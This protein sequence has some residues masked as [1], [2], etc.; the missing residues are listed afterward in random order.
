SVYTTLDAQA[1][2]W[3]VDAVRKGARMYERR[4]GWKVKFDN[5]IDQGKGG[6]GGVTLATLE[7]YR[8]PS[9]IA[10]P[11]V[12]DIMTGMIKEV[13]ERNAQVTFGSYSAVITAEQTEALSKPPSKIFKRGDLAQFKIEAVDRV[14]KTMSVMLD[15]EPDVQ[16]AL[17]LLDAKTGE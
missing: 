11:E 8:H 12:G 3:A 14:K 16:A 1:Q 15:P 2:Q 10:V 5:V 13:N 6:Q 9:W 7:A 4:H 17:L